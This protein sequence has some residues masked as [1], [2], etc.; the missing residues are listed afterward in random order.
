MD[1]RAIHYSDNYI[2]LIDTQNLYFEYLAKALL[3]I[4]NAITMIYA[5]SHIRSVRILFFPPFSNTPEPFISATFAPFLVYID[6]AL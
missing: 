5:P 4:T 6:V 2:Y 3:Y 1:V